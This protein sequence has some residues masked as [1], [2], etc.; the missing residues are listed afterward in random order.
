MQTKALLNEL[1]HMTKTIRDQAVSF[2]SLPNKTLNHKAEAGKWSALE[3][4]EHLNRYG[5]FYLPEIKKR[6]S[7]N[8]PEF[9]E[10]FIPGLLGTYFVNSVKPRAKNMNTFSNMNPSKS[11]VRPNVLQEFIHQQDQMLKILE[12]CKQ[13]NLKKVKTNISISKWIKLRLGDTLR[14]VIYHNLRHI[15]QAERA[16]LST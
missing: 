15:E 13:Y 4:L 3:C 8:R 5:D 16:I 7:K 6:L 14:V 10:V 2:K 9:T 12:D 11:S 1:I